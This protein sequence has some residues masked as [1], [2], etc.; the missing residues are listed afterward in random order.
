MKLLR[1]FVLLVALPGSNAVAATLEFPV[2]FDTAFLTDLLKESV[3]KGQQGLSVWGDEN[4]CNDLTL[5]NP[6]VLIEESA[7]FIVTDASAVTGLNVLGSCV[8][9]L[10]WTGRVRATQQA[11]VIDPA[12]KIGFTTVDTMLL[13]AEGNRAVVSD[14]LWEIARTAINPS[15]AVFQVDLTAAMASVRDVLP[16][17]LGE[18]DLAEGRDVVDSFAIDRIETKTDGIA[19]L[20]R[21][22]LDVTQRETRPVRESALSAAEIAGFE[23]VWSRWDAFLGFVIK[24]V[25]SYGLD[26]VQQDVLLEALIDTRYLLVDALSRHTRDRVDPVRDN[27]IETWQKLRPV[28][29]QI[30][31]KVKGAESLHFLGFIA[32]ADALEALDKLGPLA[33]WDISVDGLRRLARILIDNPEIDPLEINPGTDPELRQLFDFERSLELPPAQA[34]PLIN[35]PLSSWIR[36]FDWVSTPVS[37]ATRPALDKLYPTADNILEYLKSISGLLRKVS[38]STLTVNPLD[39]AFHKLF[40]DVVYATAWQET[41]WRQYKR[42]KNKLVT[43]TSSAGALGMMQVMPKVWR[44]FYEEDALANSIEYNAAAGA[45]ILHRYLVR[46]ALR[47]KEHEQKGGIDNLVRATYAAYNGGPGHLSR[48]RKKGTSGT[49]KRIDQAFWAKF[50]E[51][52]AGNEL[53]VR[54]CYSY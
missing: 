6:E 30:G 49:L 33:G 28:F 26:D 42:Q 47:K 7:L 53:G 16:K 20:V 21:F 2:Q 37:A 17:F 38:A 41:C 18:T 5:S 45:E 3:F 46:Y 1:L 4:G 31:L 34:M 32:A 24:V 25:G 9:A 13:D 36:V 39:S 50:L 12:G 48:Y 23:E 40:E 11:K 14:K 19:A 43:V 54:D 22:E 35:D 10:K 51:V 8:P 44:G 29:Q 27:F 52:R 15:Y